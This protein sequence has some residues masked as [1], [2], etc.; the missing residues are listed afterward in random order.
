MTPSSTQADQREC[1]KRTEKGKD[2][3]RLRVGLKQPPQKSGHIS[4][5]PS[6]GPA[7][8]GGLL[9]SFITSMTEGF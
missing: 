1:S 7:V 2:E 3:P 9:V 4:N 5:A 6:M 8:T